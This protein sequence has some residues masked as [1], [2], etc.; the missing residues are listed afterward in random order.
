MR[1][2][3]RIS[4]V[5]RGVGLRIRLRR[6]E[7]GLSQETL[8]EKLKV[9]FQQI[10]K[11]EKGT[12]R[13]AASRLDRLAKILDVPIAFFFNGSDEAGPAKTSAAPK[14]LELLDDVRSLRLLQAF[15]R[16]ESAQTRQAILRL[17]E[18]AAQGESR[19]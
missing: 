6:L 9:S 16:I 4:E 10:Q 19:T 2:R 15:A 5:D 3:S 7:L 13:V 11:Y 1:S 18:Q 8:G 14:V 12:N 17:I